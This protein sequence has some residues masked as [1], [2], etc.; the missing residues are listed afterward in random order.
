M[1][2]T[3]SSTHHLYWPCIL[4]QAKNS[5]H[6]NLLISAPE[7]TE[8]WRLVAVRKLSGFPHLTWQFTPFHHPNLFTCVFSGL[9][10]PTIKNNIT[11]GLTVQSYPLMF[12]QKWWKNCYPGAGLVG[13]HKQSVCAERAHSYPQDPIPL[14]SQLPCWWI[15]FGGLDIA[16]YEYTF[17]YCTCIIIMHTYSSPKK[18]TNSQ[19]SFLKADPPPNDQLNKKVFSFW[20]SWFRSSNWSLSRASV[21]WKNSSVFGISVPVGWVTSVS[22]GSHDS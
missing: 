6:E 18:R 14:I 3:L 19:C 13:Q 16:A 20:F 15:R 17:I 4:S 22:M 2:V 21:D 8:M 9:W 7:T 12:N 5:W 1:K 10:K 11:H